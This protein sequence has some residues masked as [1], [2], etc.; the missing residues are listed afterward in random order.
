MEILILMLCLLPTAYI[1]FIAKKF[2]KS[3][4][5]LP[6]GPRPLPIIGN[7][8]LLGAKPHKSL[9]KLAQT[10]GPI[11]TLKQG[12]VTAIVI[13]SAPAAKLVLQ[14]HDHLFANRFVPKAFQT[15]DIEKFSVAWTSLSPKWRHLRKVPNSLIFSKQKMDA[16]GDLMHQKVEELIADARRK[17]TI[18]EPM[19]I[20]EAAFKSS[21]NVLSKMILS[22]DF[23]DG[24]SETARE[25]KKVFRERMELAGTPN[26]VDFFPLLERFDPQRIRARIIPNNLKI[27]TMFDRMI[28]ERLARRAEESSVFENRDV[29]DNLLNLMQD[30][31]DDLTRDDIIH[32]LLDLFVAGTDTTSSTLEWAMTEVLRNPEILT[33]AKSEL[34]RVTNKGKPIQDEEVELLPYLQAII[35]ETLRLHPPTPLLLPRKNFEP[36]ELNGYTIPKG[37]QVVV[38]AWAIGRDPGAWENPERFEPERFLGLSNVSFVGGNFELIPFG[39]GRRICPGLSLAVKMLQLML[40][41]LVNCFEWK[42]EDGQCPEDIDMDEKF[43]ITLSKTHPLKAVPLPI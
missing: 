33:K 18:G 22:I 27:L 5:N 36:V 38:N 30:S 12:Q 14:K 31:N 17:C 23:A 43:G 7:L 16:N 2:K 8:H 13:S 19:L 29:L 28:D 26:L 24:E 10:H 40:G 1:L 41:S 32:L 39:G 37:A 35:N 9:A 15:S 25:F 21:L 20:G 11:M 34:E 4:S 42:L 3:S 6:P